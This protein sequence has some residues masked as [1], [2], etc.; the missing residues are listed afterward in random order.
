MSNASYSTLEALASSGKT[1][2]VR[3]PTLKAIMY[4]SVD[5]YEK[6][7]LEMPHFAEGLTGLMST[8]VAHE[9]RNIGF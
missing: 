3:Q 2:T 1:P 6:L 9:C 8:M 5:D 4:R 7:L